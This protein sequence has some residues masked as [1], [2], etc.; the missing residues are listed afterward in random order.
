MVSEWW[1]LSAEVVM[2]EWWW[3]SGE[4]DAVCQRH[5]A[6]KTI[7]SSNVVLL[8]RSTKKKHRQA[9]KNRLRKSKK[10]IT[11]CDNDTCKK[12]RRGTTAAKNGKKREFKTLALR[13]CA[14]ASALATARARVCSSIAD[15]SRVFSSLDSSTSRFSKAISLSRS[16]VSRSAAARVDPSSVA[17]AAR[18]AA[19]AS[20]TR[21]R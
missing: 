13:T 21:T 15:A 10:N 12:G 4:H 5:N 17:A 6:G 3:M 18:S 14:R 8:H 2:G 1:W 7:P 9:K 20:L 16:A 19:E 11:A